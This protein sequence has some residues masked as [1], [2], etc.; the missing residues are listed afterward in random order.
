MKIPYVI[1]NIH[2]R[3]ADVLNYLLEAQPHQQV[4]IALAYFSIRGYQQVRANLS[5]VGGMRLLLGDS[6][7]VCG[8]ET[9]RYPPPYDEVD[10][11]DLQERVIADILGDIEQQQAAAL[12][13]KPVAEE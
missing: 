1:D 6:P 10:I 4:D 11:Y 3:L 7:I 5:H 12:V 9:P 2:T 13:A 8:P